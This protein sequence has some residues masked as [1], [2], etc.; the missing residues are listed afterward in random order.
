MCLDGHFIA[1][2]LSEDG[3]SLASEQNPTL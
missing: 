3:F 2:A 1:A